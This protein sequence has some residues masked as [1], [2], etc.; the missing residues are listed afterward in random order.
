M[1]NNGIGQ[2]TTGGVFQAQI[3]I[4]LTVVFANDS[5][6]KFIEYSHEEFENLFHC[7]LIDLISPRSAETILKEM[8]SQIRC[9][10]GFSVDIEMLVGGGLR[11]WMWLNADI[12]NDETGKEYLYCIFSDI[13]LRQLEQEKLKDIQQRYQFVLNHVEDIIFE[14]DYRTKTMY[15]MGGQNATFNYSQ[16]INCFPE[17]LV[18]DGLKIHPDDV[19][20]FFDNYKKYDRGATE[21]FA[22]YRIR[23]N[24]GIYFWCSSTSVGVF[25]NNK[26]VKVLGRISNI[27]DQKIQLLEMSRRA[28][29]DPL[30][31]LYNRKATESL[32]EQYIQSTDNMAAMLV[33]DLDNFK[34]V[35][36]TLGHLRGDTVINEIAAGITSIFRS[37]DII[38][39]IGGDEF[40]VFLTDVHSQEAIVHVVQSV[41]KQF[42]I[43]LT[44][45]NIKGKLSGSIGISVY[46][47]DAKSF[48]EL[49]E[50]ADI[51]L[52]RAKNTGKNRFV[53]YTDDLSRQDFWADCNIT[54]HAIRTPNESQRR[55][56]LYKLALE[57]TGAITW[58]FDIKNK[59]IQSLLSARKKM[60]DTI[61]YENF[62]QDLID[63]GYIHVDS[64]ASLLEM[65]KQLSEGV[66]DVSS[67]I[68]TID[69]VNNRWEWQ[70]ISY[71]TLFDDDGIP[72]I[73]VG[74]SKNITEQ[75]NAEIKY[76][77]ATEKYTLLK[78]GRVSISISNLTKNV[79]EQYYHCESPDTNETNMHGYD[80]MVLADISHIPNPNDAKRYQLF[81]R[82][83]LLEM[84][85]VGETYVQLEFRCSTITGRLMWVSRSISLLKDAQNGDIY[86]YCISR[87]ID[88]QK[89]QELS[90]ASRATMDCLTGAYDQITARELINSSIQKEHM[91][92]ACFSLINFKVD[93]YYP[94]ITSEGVSNAQAVILELSRLLQYKFPNQIVGRFFD[95]QL[96]VMVQDVDNYEKITDIANDIR[97]AIKVNDRFSQYLI[98]V[99]ISV[100][101]VFDSDTTID[102]ESTYNYTEIALD[103][104]QKSGYNKCI[105]YTSCTKPA[106]HNVDGLFSIPEAK[107]VILRCALALSEFGENRVG[108]LTLLN[109]MGAFYQPYRIFISEFSRSSDHEKFSFVW[110]DGS[111]KVTQQFLPE[112]LQ[113]AC[114]YLFGSLEKNL[115]VIYND[116]SVLKNMYPQD[117]RSLS[118]KGVRSIFAGIMKS[119]N[120]I[121]GYISVVNPTKNTDDSLFFSTLH[122]FL[123]SE[124]EKH[125]L[126]EKRNF[127][128]S[129]DSLTSLLNRNSYIDYSSFLKEESLIS[130]GVV[131]ADINGLKFINSQK[132]HEY[133]DLAVCNV[134]DTLKNIFG[135]YY[136]YRFAG[137]EFLVVCEN[138]SQEALAE[139]V[140]ALKT[141]CL[142]FTDFSVSTGYV[143]SDVDMKLETLVKHSDEILMGEKQEY[144]LLSG[145]KTKRNDPNESNKLLQQIKS[146]S[147]I[148]YLQPQIS[149]K[150]G[151]ISGAEALVRYCDESNIVIYPDK[152]IPQ[153]EK[154]GL[155]KHIDIMMTRKVCSLLR[156]WIDDGKNPPC[157]SINLSRATILSGNIIQEICSIADEYC[158]PRSLIE[159]EITESFGE[160]ERETIASIGR[161]VSTA[162][163][164]LALDDFGAKY[165]NFAILSAANWDTLKVDKSLIND[166]FSN[167]RTQIILQKL[168]ETCQAL[169]IKSV[170]EGVET[171][172]QYEA[173]KLLGCD[174]I[175]G[176]YFNKPM[177]VDKFKDAYLK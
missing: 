45:L 133:G 39:R 86:A 37:T 2:F 169:N 151:D 15:Q 174:D 61:S 52:Y 73:A 8:Q 74:I 82:E 96:I 167:K 176:Y 132:G 145:N 89:R 78:E 110:S 58:L 7:R 26:L 177:P 79:V 67:E 101:V 70:L 139:K 102:F 80:D 136:C 170:S 77:Q 46:P 1:T 124:M 141:A 35:N 128:S 53:I 148:M 25:E 159:L 14:W 11:K 44:G 10:Q 143:W 127:L 57:K 30:T 173:L 55:E 83:A 146:N 84:F 24:G 162:G 22:E 88:S 109:E 115:L 164:R 19:A 59:R 66:H 62:P 51:A 63:K 131:S 93:R 152:F 81:S 105:V 106:P 99:S 104:A 134:A 120:E 129:H 156:K 155:I 72:D 135:N 68:C 92:G 113:K 154:N 150:T 20:I 147:F 32:I 12:I 94:I 158:V 48:N 161:Q 112:D 114:P 142:N 13:T 175:Q 3:D 126:Y 29:R 108:I 28:M 119:G 54:R 60:R 38:G 27:N 56:D 31:E 125:Q 18:K 75:K 153:Y 17:D 107:D 123:S 87:E 5:F 171:K 116:I 76:Q 21:A 137:D 47:N 90:L 34:L 144:Y 122:R 103:T 50:K 95:D 166:I 172:E 165:S 71:T 91:A 64:I 85:N 42:D 160:L 98:P 149:T 69:T 117:Y 23:T 16:V 163:F 36:D 41:L 111:A 6:Y 49:L 97:I 100:G 118:E 168:F 140:I 33:I 121:I 157:T 65:Y 9:G 43:T 130:L 40:V 4:N 138:I